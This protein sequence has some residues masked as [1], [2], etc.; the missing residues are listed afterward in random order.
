MKL[1]KYGIL[2]LITA[3]MYFGLSITLYAQG[4]LAETATTMDLQQQMRSGQ[5]QPATANPATEE[6]QQ[7]IDRFEKVAEKIL[8]SMQTGSFDSEDFSAAWTS[9]LPADADFSSAMNALCRQVVAQFGRAE[10]L[11]QGKIIGPNKATFPVQ[12]SG[13][14]LDMTFSLDPQ[15][16]I[17]EWTLTPP[18]TP[19]N[20]ATG[21]RTAETIETP[22]EAPV[23]PEEAN[24]PDISDFN[25]FQREI[26][27]MN[28][29]TRSEEQM[30][31][32]ETVQKAE[33]A[34]AIEELVTA[35]LLFIRK[36]AESENAEDTVKAVTLVLQQRR[37]R[38]AG[39]EEQLREERQQLMLDRREGRASRGERPDRTERERSRQRVPRRSTEPTNE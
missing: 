26:N 15:D 36:L 33:L 2:L 28:I 13:G 11:G 20:P 32:G 16:K 12:F 21:E 17:A 7:T 14:T 5:Y 1:F 37:E 25:S 27:R 4:T 6:N 24:T 3:A 8:R 35:Q 23:L 38:L 9:N 30:W 39:L 10:Q 31:L 18:A 29:E 34:R 22:A 19:S